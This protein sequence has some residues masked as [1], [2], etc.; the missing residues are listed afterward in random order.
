MSKQQ[1]LHKD[2]EE[3]L[4]QKLV[5]WGITELTDVQQKALSAGAASGKSL[6]VS[7]P[8]SSGKT[9]ENA[10]ASSGSSAR[11]RYRR[12]GRFLLREK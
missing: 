1:L 2:L 11:R 5:S 9:R 12:R 10:S 4:S 7:A 8:T 6:I 3:W